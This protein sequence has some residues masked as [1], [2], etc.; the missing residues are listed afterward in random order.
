MRTV[1]LHLP[2]RDFDRLQE[3][4][5]SRKKTVGVRTDVLTVALADYT[6]LAAAV[7]LMGGMIIDPPEEMAIDT[8]APKQTPDAEVIRHLNEEISRLRAVLHPNKKTAGTMSTLPLFK[9]S[10]LSRDSRPLEAA[11]ATV[12]ATESDT[13]AGTETSPRRAN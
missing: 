6:R 8:S 1:K 3:L 10:G 9:H 7:E 11:S 13:D 4:C 12:P 2:L 5:V